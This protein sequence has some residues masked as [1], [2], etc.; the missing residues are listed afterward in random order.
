MVSG[1]KQNKT[2]F[3]LLLLP[4]VGQ[5]F[6]QFYLGCL[7]VMLSFLELIF[8]TSEIG[9]RCGVSLQELSAVQVPEP[10]THRHTP[11]TPAH[12]RPVSG[13]CTQAHTT[14]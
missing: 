12:C 1:L 5:A 7:C 3:L 13:V 4:H 9:M 8:S 11:Q 2:L 6:G 14:Y 10:L